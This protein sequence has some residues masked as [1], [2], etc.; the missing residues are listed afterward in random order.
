MTICK[1]MHMVYIFGMD[2]PTDDRGVPRGPRGPKKT[3][4]DLSCSKLCFP[5]GHTQVSS[6]LQVGP[7]MQG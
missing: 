6:T 2:R 4:E 1:A 5:P 3:R 7:A